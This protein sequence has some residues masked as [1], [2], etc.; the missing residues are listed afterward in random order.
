[1]NDVEAINYQIECGHPCHIFR[2]R[3][4]GGTVLCVAPS[5]FRAKLAFVDFLMAETGS[6]TIDKLSR[7]EQHAIVTKAFMALRARTDASAPQGKGSA[8]SGGDAGDGPDGQGDP[9]DA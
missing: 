7:K 4:G 8:S 6:I 9:G 1:M 5:E 2:F 3:F